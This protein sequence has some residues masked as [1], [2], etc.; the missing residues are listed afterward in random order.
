[1]YMAIGW[2][3]NHPRLGFQLDDACG[4]S[5]AE[6]IATSTSNSAPALAAESVA[7]LTSG[8]L[9]RNPTGVA[10]SST[11][12]AGRWRRSRRQRAA[13]ESRSSVAAW[14]CDSERKELEIH[15]NNRQEIMSGGIIVRH[16]SGAIARRSVQKIWVQTSSPMGTV[17]YLEMLRRTG[18]LLRRW[19]GSCRWCCIVQWWWGAVQEELWCDDCRASV[20]RALRRRL[21]AKVD[22]ELD[23]NLRC[24]R[25][26]E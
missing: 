24:C 15:C 8:P 26:S 11:A 9:G 2:V 5:R 3:T 7:R 6:E 20:Q 1:M 12:S 10:A 18:D 16:I 14:S 22:W 25:R 4:R 23:A 17:L 21:V 13:E 19:G